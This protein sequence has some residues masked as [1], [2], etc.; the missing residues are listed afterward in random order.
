[1]PKYKQRE[2]SKRAVE[3]IK[4][5]PEFLG[6]VDYKAPKRTVKVEK[7]AIAVTQSCYWVQK[8][9]KKPIVEAELIYER[10]N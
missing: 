1:M 7:D 2:H 6:W 5:K 3:L 8:S 10:K 9:K 4:Q